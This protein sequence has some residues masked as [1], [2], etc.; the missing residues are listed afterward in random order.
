VARRGLLMCGIAGVVLP[1][2][3]LAD[4]S[5]VA[6]MLSGMY[7]RGPDDAGWLTLDCK[8]VHRGRAAGEAPA[9][10]LAL[11]NRRLAILDLSDDGWQPMSSADGR[12]HLTYNGEI[13]NYVE[14]RAELEQEGWAFRSHSDT[15]VLL[16]ALA[17]WGKPALERL[18]GMFA[19]AFLDV[20]DRKLLLAR[21]FFGIKPLYY[22]GWR[23]GIA[24][25]SEMKLL[26]GLPGLDKQLNPHRLYQY[27]RF[28]L[29]SH[30]S[31][32]MLSA[33][34]Q[35]PAAHYLELDIDQPQGAQP[36]RFW[37]LAPRPIHGIS[38][39]EA[40]E[41]L[42][43]LFLDS[44]RIHLRS[45]VPVGAAVSGGIDSSALLTAMR[46]LEGPKLEIHAFSYI[47]EGDALSEEKWVDLA[48]KRAGAVV[49]K[50][51]ARPRELLDDLDALILAQD[52]PF[53]STSIYAQYRVFRLAKEC[54]IKVTL[55]GQGA[56][57]ILAGYRP[58][59]AA[60]IASCLRG[61]R[62][63]EAGRLARAAY[64]YP[65]AQ[66]V[67][68][69]YQAG[70][71]LL[72][73]RLE[74]VSRRAVGADLVPDW[75][76]ARWFTERG[77][78]MTSLARPAGP[79][80]LRSSLRASVEQTS[81]PPLL[82][83]EDRNSMA[84]SVES[85]VPFLTP[86]LVTFCLSLPEQYLVSR[87][88]TSKAV[89]RKAM[90]GIVPD[91]ILARRDKIGFET[92]EA[93]WMRELGGWVSRVLESPA[94]DLIGGLDAAAVRADWQGVQAGERPFDTRVWRWVNLIRWAELTG[95]AGS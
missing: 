22:A 5:F 52:E 64:S 8:E 11:V 72:P 9:A 10:R 14:L 48:G 21:D 75:L 16:A 6:A 20:R 58:Y 33:V 88:G 76:N 82:R 40:A 55:D 17:T 39:D 35:L 78:R 27:L 80:L 77:V 29:T 90:R 94:I 46:F 81:L 84:H 37:R 60:R 28:G 67:R 73:R 3:E 44:V 12:Y 65:D 61:G 38:F 34:R 19:F 70:G 53:R 95:A 4:P 49:H 89:F 13:Y 24:F 63:L 71:F 68:M 1:E 59:V 57:E 32:T 2:G 62:V 7:H 85:R 93:A 45:D 41:R 47:A 91:E 18:V 36:V 92:P 15:E 42:R 31:E 26:L 66:A 51:R 54:G 83:Y 43:D 69:L 87:D 86:E 23:G 50:V 30:G 74:A 56:D 25:G 79:N